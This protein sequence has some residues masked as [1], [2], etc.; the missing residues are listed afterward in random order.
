MIKGGIPLYDRFPQVQFEGIYD[1][2]KINHYCQQKGISNGIVKWMARREQRYL[3]KIQSFQP[4]LVFKLMLSP[5]ES[6]RRKPFENLETVT[7]KHEITQQLQFPN[8]AVY[9]VDATQ[10]YQQEII[11]IKNKIWEAIIQDQ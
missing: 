6:I 5:E 11:F 4:T 10:D 7:R 2:P 9:I 3:E 1:G 8:S